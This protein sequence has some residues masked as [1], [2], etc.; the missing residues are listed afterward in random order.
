MKTYKERLDAL[1][2]QVKE[3]TRALQRS[4]V[5]ITPFPSRRPPSTTTELSPIGKCRVCLGAR[6]VGDIEC[7]ECR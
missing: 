7:P 4:G 2:E 6:L 5:S 1:E 3:L